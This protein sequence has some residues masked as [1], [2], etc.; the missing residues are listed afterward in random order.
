MNFI[1]QVLSRDQDFVITFELQR[2]SSFVLLRQ[3]LRIFATI[4][5]RGKLKETHRIEFLSR[6]KWCSV[7]TLKC[8]PSILPKLLI[9]LQLFW[10][11]AMLEDKSEQN[12][13]FFYSMYFTRKRL[14]WQ[15][16]SSFFMSTSCIF[17]M[18][19]LWNYLNISHHERNFIICGRF[20][21]FC[22][23]KL[24]LTQILVDM[25]DLSK[26]PVRSKSY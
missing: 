1:G 20:Y 23:E 13:W 16:V 9:L 19:A 2:F 24:L 4:D 11:Y 21:K 12:F 17:L 22:N 14:F 25:T 5:S 6:V 26:I 7:Y 18:M 10:V 8:L 3:F 15:L